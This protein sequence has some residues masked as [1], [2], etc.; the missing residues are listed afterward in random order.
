MLMFAKNQETASMGCDFKP[1]RASHPFDMFCCVPPELG[2]QYLFS[3]GRTIFI[4]SN[5]R[6]P[7]Y[8]NIPFWFGCELCWT[9][10]IGKVTRQLSVGFHMGK[11]L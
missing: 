8:W 5:R 6:S 2:Y 4:G 1:H 10:L 11:V 9:T 3:L 7:Y